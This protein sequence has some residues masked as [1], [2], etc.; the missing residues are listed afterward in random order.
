MISL[1]PNT[2]AADG[3][4]ERYPSFGRS[5]PRNGADSGRTYLRRVIPG[6]FAGKLVALSA[7]LG[8]VGSAVWTSHGVTRIVLQ[9]CLGAVFAH[10]TELIHQ[11]LHRTAT[12]RAS[13]DQFFGMLIATPLVISFWR[14]LHDHFRHHKDV[15]QESFSYNYERMESRS[16]PVRLLGAI[17]HLSMLNHFV[18]TLK[19]ICYAL[20]G[21]V[22][23]K[24]AASGSRPTQTVTHRIRRD[25]LIMAGLIAA[26]L[27]ITIGLRTDAVIQLWLIPMIIGWAPIHALIE[28]PEHW[29]CD[30]STTNPRLNTRSIRAGK[31]ARWY[32]NNNCNHVGHHYDLSVA[33]ERLPEYEK[34]LMAESP[35]NHFE[36]SYPKFYLRFFSFIFTR[37]Y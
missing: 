16:M 22:D 28:L 27:L 8:V 6:Y 17:L 30:T 3:L 24:L 33:M 12:G 7:L 1:K 36:Q 14:Y 4:L 23:Q 20:T 9:V 11:C 32:V 21:K 13:R 5:L 26:G 2:L 31:L 34:Q 25:Y 37:K 29:K 15:T 35:F 10:G 19:W 18:E